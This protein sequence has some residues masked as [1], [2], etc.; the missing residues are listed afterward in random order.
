MKYFLL[1]FLVLINM[2]E[3]DDDQTSCINNPISPDAVCVEIYDPVCGCDDVTYSN[4]CYA[5]ASGVST[6]TDGECPD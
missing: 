2:C 4:A 6:W 1:S 5:T 3:K